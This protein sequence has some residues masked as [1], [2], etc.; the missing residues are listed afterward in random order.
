MRP[1]FSGASVFVARGMGKRRNSPCASHDRSRTIHLIANFSA[2]MM[3]PI[4]SPKARHPEIL[5]TKSIKAFTL[6]DVV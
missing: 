2:R 4:F 1:G 3:M 6:L 5:K